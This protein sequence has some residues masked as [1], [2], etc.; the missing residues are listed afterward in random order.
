MVTLQLTDRE[1]EVI[2]SAF[3]QLGL[4]KHEPAMYD[5]FYAPIAKTDEHKRVKV[6]SCLNKIQFVKAIMTVTGMGVSVSKDIADRVV[7]G[8]LLLNE[9]SITPDK[10]EQIAQI[11]SVNLK[12]E[13]V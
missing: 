13:Y 11:Q 3:V 2:S 4:D 12:W 8:T 7:G 10:W 1:C 6:T 9:S 5:K